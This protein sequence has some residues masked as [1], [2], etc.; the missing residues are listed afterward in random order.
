MLADKNNIFIIPDGSSVPIKN[1]SKNYENLLTVFVSHNYFIYAGSIS[2]KIGIHEFFSNRTQGSRVMITGSHCSSIFVDLMN[3]AYCSIFSL[4]KVVRTEINDNENYPETIAGTG[5]SSLSN[6]S[7]SGPHGIFVDENFSLYVADSRN[8]RI[9]LFKYG[10]HIG[11]TVIGSNGL[12]RYNLSRPISVIADAVDNIYVVEYD[13]HRIVVTSGNSVRC[14]I[15]CSGTT[16]SLNYQLNRPLSFMF[17]NRGN[18]FVADRANS[19]I[20]KFIRKNLHCGMLLNKRSYICQSR[21]TND[22][23]CFIDSSTQFRTSQTT[24]SSKTI[25]FD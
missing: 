11:L 4:N 7:L 18:I 17:D 20:Q 15:G 5:C 10:Q 22:R 12:Y 19:R 24:E 6:T 9:Q 21:F 2:L 16:G 8:N 1:V 13:T 25:S 3:R 14:I 23:S